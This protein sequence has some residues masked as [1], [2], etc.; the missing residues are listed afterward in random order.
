[1]HFAC[2]NLLTEI[3]NMPESTKTIF[4]QGVLDNRCRKLTGEEIKRIEEDVKEEA[5]VGGDLFKMI[6]Q[7]DIPFKKSY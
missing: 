3:S 5:I 6:H 2:L 1:M 7:G 4:L